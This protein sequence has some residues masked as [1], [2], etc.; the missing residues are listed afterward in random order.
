MSL[1]LK[2]I[3]GVSITASSKEEILEYLKKC[4]ENKGKTSAKSLIIVTPNPEQVVLAQKNF[5]FAEILNRAD[6]AIPDGIGVVW[7]SRILNPIVHIS[8]MS[9]VEFMEDLV[10]IAAE[11]HV[12]IGLIG[13]RGGVAVEALECLEK[14]HSGLGGWAMDGP[15]LE[16]KSFC[17]PAWRDPWSETVQPLM[18][19]RFHGN[20]RVELD[21]FINH[22]VD[23]IEK[24]HTRIIFVGLGAP[25]Q[26][27]FIDAL[28]RQFQISNFKFQIILMAVG[29]AFDEISGRLPMPPKFIDRYGLKWL[30]R[31]I[32]EPWR[33]RRQVALLKFMWLVF[34]EKIRLL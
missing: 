2:K 32:L 23:R 20:D 4:L 7:A 14:K 19:S 29:G 3:L 12:P 30:W 25:K 10:K 22:L 27:Y 31:L 1:K 16:I 26:E 17:H 11:R 33:W 13:G 28:A 15:E 21:Q 9:G 8:R 18:D 5:H 34:I 6:V 24:D